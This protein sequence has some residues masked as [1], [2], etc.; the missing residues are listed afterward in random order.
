MSQTSLSMLKSYVCRPLVQPG[1]FC[2]AGT[3]GRLLGGLSL[4]G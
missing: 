3:H 1:T 4:G 2:W